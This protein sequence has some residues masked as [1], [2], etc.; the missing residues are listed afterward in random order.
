MGRFRTD[1]DLELSKMNSTLQS[2]HE[3]RMPQRRGTARFNR[4]AV[5][6]NTTAACYTST[7]CY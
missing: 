6:L 4:R 5:D 3:R 2:E 1:A 7:T